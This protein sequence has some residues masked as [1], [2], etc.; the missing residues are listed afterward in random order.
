MPHKRVHGGLKLELVP[1]PNRLSLAR[2]R[3][4]TGGT[5]QVVDSMEI[6]MGKWEAVCGRL[7]DTDTRHGDLIRHPW[8]LGTMSE[9]LAARAQHPSLALSEMIEERC[10]PDLTDALRKLHDPYWE[11]AFDAYAPRMATRPISDSNPAADPTWRPLRW[12]V[13]QVALDMNLV[14]DRD[15]AEVGEM[16]AGQWRPRQPDQTRERGRGPSR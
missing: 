10:N 4:L 14:P 5:V 15:R 7:T 6:C 12:L 1:K 2:V 11:A 8:D 13:A 9:E 16:A 3:G